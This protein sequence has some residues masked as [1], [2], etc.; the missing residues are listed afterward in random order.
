MTNPPSFPSVGN[1]FGVAVS[2]HGHLVFLLPPRGG[3]TP[4]EAINLAA[5]LLALT[6]YSLYEFA[7]YYQLVSEA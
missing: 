2:N 6:P 1:Q 3:L 5:Y 4:E 7:T